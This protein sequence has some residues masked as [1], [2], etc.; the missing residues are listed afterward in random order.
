MIDFNDALDEMR[1]R[2]GRE[3]NVRIADLWERLCWVGGLE[4]I[5]CGHF[6]IEEKLNSST[7]EVSSFSED[8]LREFCYPE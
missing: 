8:T 5:K 3:P 2:I 1:E 6:V 7:E 4:A